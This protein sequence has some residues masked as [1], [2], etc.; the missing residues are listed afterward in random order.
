MWFSRTEHRGALLCDPPRAP[1]P[2]ALASPF[3]PSCG[4]PVTLSPPAPFLPASP[5][6]FPPVSWTFL[7]WCLPASPSLSSRGSGASSPFPG[8]ISHCVLS[9]TE[10][11]EEP[12]QRAE[13]PPCSY[14]WERPSAAGQGAVVSASSEEGGPDPQFAQDPRER[15]AC[16]W[17]RSVPVCVTSST[18]VSEGR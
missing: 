15:P 9:A 16:A 7:P 17:H 13:E 5:A 14:C 2:L 18:K 4:S 12:Q 3:L 8:T 11:S 6:C 10:G 1:G